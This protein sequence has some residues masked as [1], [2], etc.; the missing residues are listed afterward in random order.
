MNETIRK[1]TFL[2]LEN[3][4]FYERVFKKLNKAEVMI[5]LDIIHMLKDAS[6]DEFEAQINRVFL[7]RPDKTRHYKEIVELLS[8]TNTLVK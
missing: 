4:P 1:L 3:H 5:A 8:A 7:D 6:R 2:E